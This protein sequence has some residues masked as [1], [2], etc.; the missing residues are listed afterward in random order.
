MLVLV[1]WKRIPGSLT[2][3][4]AEY[5]NTYRRN[6]RIPNPRPVRNARVKID[7]SVSPWRYNNG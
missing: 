1:A 7:F 6:S 2:I 3:T 5:T 4:G